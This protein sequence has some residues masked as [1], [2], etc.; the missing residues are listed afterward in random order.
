[1]T[2]KV[3]R[4]RLAADKYLKNLKLFIISGLFFV[5]N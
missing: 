5:H 4:Y 1:M 3:L 2:S